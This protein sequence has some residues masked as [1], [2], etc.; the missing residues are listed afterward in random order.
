VLGNKTKLYSK[1]ISVNWYWSWLYSFIYAY[2][3]QVCSE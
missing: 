2:P 1:R 3:S